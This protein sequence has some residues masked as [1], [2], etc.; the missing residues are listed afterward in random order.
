MMMKLNSRLLMFAFACLLSA[1]AWAQ[2]VEPEMVLV[3]GG[4]FMMGSSTGDTDE[5]PIHE[6]VVRNF[7]ISKYEITVAQYQEFCNSTN[8]VM[9]TA[10]PWGWDAQNP[11]CLVSWKDA[12]AYA[13]WLSRKTGK[14]Y[15]LPTE[16]E[17]EYAARGGQQ[18]SA[19]T[20]AGSDDPDKVAWYYE[21]TYGSGPQPVGRKAPNAVGIYDMSGNVWEWCKDEYTLQY[22]PQGQETYTMGPSGENYRVLRGGG[23]N[24]EAKHTRITNRD[25]NVPASSNENAGFRVVRDPD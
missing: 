21:T 22:Y 10:P 6:V 9:P 13:L 19:T 18:D 8:W 16:A 3:K 11:M 23:W 4:T 7:Y 14:S 17:W 20:Y 2:I 15:R 12:G 5:R 25:R 24:S 1:G